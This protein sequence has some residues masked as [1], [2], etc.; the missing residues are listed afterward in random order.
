MS[1]IDSI[2]SWSRGGALLSRGAAPTLA[3]RAAARCRGQGRVLPRARLDFDSGRAESAGVRPAHHARST[4]GRRSHD[5]SESSFPEQAS[6]GSRHRRGDRRRGASRGPAAEG[7]RPRQARPRGRPLG[8]VGAVRRGHHPRPHRR[9]GRD[10]RGRRDPRRAHDRAHPPGR[11]VEPAEGRHR[12]P[13]AH[14]QG[15]GRGLLRRHR[16]SGVAR[17]RAARQQVQ[18]PVHGG[19][20]GRDPDHPQRRRPQLRLPGIGGRRHR[21]H[22]APP[23]RASRRSARR[24]SASC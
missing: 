22:Q 7:R 12:G 24:R 2:R 8:A 3:G 11:R 10:Q 23:V 5:K 15:G 1:K 20:G 21:R 19:V 6:P 4:R 18:G 13:R 17:H 16:L 14:L 9:D